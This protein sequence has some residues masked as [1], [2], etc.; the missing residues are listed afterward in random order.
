MKLEFATIDTPAAFAALRED[1][2]AL[3]RRSEVDHAFM[4]HEWFAAWLQH[5]PWRGEL[6]ILTA[7][8]DGRLVGAAPLGL[9]RTRRRGLTVRL[10]TFLQSGISPR[11]HFLVDRDEDPRAVFAGLWSIEGWDLAE[12]QGLAAASPLTGRLVDY[13]QGRG[14]CVVE[15]GG[16]SPYQDMPDSWE[17]FEKTRSKGFRKRFRN[18]YNRCRK[19]EGYELVKIDTAEGLDAAFPEMLE[20]SR[21]SWK[22]EGGTDLV[23]QSGMGEFFRDFARNTASEGLWVVF[24]LRIEGRPAAFDYY[25]RHDGRLVGLRW[26]YDESLGYYMPGVVVHVAAIKDLI[27]GGGR[28]FDLAGTDTDFKSGLVDTAREHLD[29]TFARGGLR[30]RLL[31]ALKDALVQGRRDKLLPGG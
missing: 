9:V 18:S 16:L 17:A 8:R 13:L 30:S 15:A 11:C 7:R 29:V 4:R 19:A 3:A 1:W 20:I 27:E 23:T 24:L 26:E 25:V 28:E 21:N 2:N 5:L 14:T 10:L 12:L 6:R 31:I 22:A